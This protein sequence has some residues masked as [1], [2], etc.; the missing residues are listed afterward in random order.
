MRL[1]FDENLSEALVA[2]LAGE[3]PGSLHVRTLG[4]GGAPDVQVWDTAI[5]HDA[6]L[7]SRDEDYRH[8][9]TRLGAPPKVIWLRLGNCTTAEVSALLRQRLGDVRHFVADAQ[10]SFLALG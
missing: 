10:A 6:I 5:R 3:F 7:V 2:V 8:L 4:L 1:L 9:S